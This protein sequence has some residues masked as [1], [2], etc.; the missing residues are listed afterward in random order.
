MSVANL[1]EA[2]RGAKRVY[3]CGNG[4]SAANAMHIAN[5]LVACGVSAIP[6]TADIAT[7]T[8]IANDHGYVHVFERQILTHGQAGDLLIALSGSG[9]STNILFA[10]DAAKELG[11]NTWAIVG[12]KGG[13]APRHAANSIKMGHDMQA[14][15]EAQLLIGHQI[16]RALR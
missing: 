9:N 10:L 12:D 15:E 3:I 1:I 7:L 11:M 4:G 16:M 8:A 6:L 14:A 5:D 13:A 2:V